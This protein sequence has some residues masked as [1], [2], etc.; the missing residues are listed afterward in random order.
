MEPLYIL[1][2]LLCEVLNVLNT[3]DIIQDSGVR[4]AKVGGTVTLPCTC[5]HNAVTY[6]YWYYQIQGEKPRIIS[7]QMKYD[8]EAEISPAYK[9]RFRV[10]VRSE[11]GVN[12]LIITDLQPS[13][14]GTYYCVMLEFNAI[15]FGRGVFLHVKTSSSNPQPSKQQP[16]LKK[17]LRLGGSVNL[18][19]S[20]SAEPCEGERNLYWFR[21][22]ASQPPLMYPSE[23]RCTSLYN[24]TLYGINCTST[25]E[26]D[27]VRSSDAG[28]YHCALASCGSV[29]FGGG[30]KVEVAVPSVVVGSLSVALALSTIGLLVLSFWRYKLKSKL[31]SSC[32][33]KVSIVTQHNSTESL[34]Y[35]ALNLKRS[36][37]RQRQEDNAESA[38]VYSRV[39]SR[40]E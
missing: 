37:E 38:C 5:Q 15:E 11:A 40:K 2:L 8:G 27:P 23:G 16:T 31:C 6:F 10:L 25:L 32:K 36:V 39:R 17:L 13:D 28:T 7:K 1:L 3:L 12:D 30:T 34:H 14:S 24:E 33:G 35:A 26:L 4:T 18:S 21:R 20:V 29:V 9:E 19:C 22:T